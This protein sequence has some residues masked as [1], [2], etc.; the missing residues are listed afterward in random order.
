M[1]LNTNLLSNKET[2]IEETL[3][4][5]SDFKCTLPLKEVKSVKVKAKAS[6]FEDFIDVFI[7]LEAETIMESSYSLK[8][9][10]YTLK[11][12]EEYHF[13]DADDGDDL[14]PY[15]GAVIDLD[16]YIFNLLSASVPMTFKGKGETL[17]SGSED[18]RVLSEEDYLK[19]KDSS[20][21][22]RFAKLDEIDFD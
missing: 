21:D 20:G 4:V 9:I 22:P 12:S 14:I 17:P 16:V 10:P 3:E 13:G 15:K 5:P 7:H 1:K 8:L 19:E 6:K 11:T 2:I 18:F